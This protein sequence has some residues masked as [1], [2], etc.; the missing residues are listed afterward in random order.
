MDII[1]AFIGIV[2]G[3]FIGHTNRQVINTE[4]SDQQRAEYEEKIKYYKDLCQ[5]HVDHT[6]RLK[7]KLREY[8][9]TAR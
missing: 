1:F 5:W 9:K 3:W 8:D 7:E 2:L 6:N 4:I